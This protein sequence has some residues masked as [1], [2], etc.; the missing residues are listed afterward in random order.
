MSVNELDYEVTP[1]DV[2]ARRKAGEKLCLIDVREESEW[3]ICR[4]D[5]ANLVPMN[6]VPG[7]VAEL[8]AQAGATPLIVYCHHG[9]RSL[10]VV[11]WLRRNGVE[12]CQSMAGGIERWSVEIDAGVPRY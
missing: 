8:E 1:T 4:I 3:R 11:H 10:Q 9:V 6:T 2:E 5:G 12:N 7:R